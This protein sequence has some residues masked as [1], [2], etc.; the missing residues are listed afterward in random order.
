[1]DVLISLPP[2]GLRNPGTLP[3]LR[4]TS[5]LVCPMVGILARGYAI[6]KFN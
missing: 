4:G 6:K 5:F 3:I 2:E 1:M